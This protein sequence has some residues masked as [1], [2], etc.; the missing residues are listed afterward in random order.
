MSNRMDS[1][2]V[3]P[4]NRADGHRVAGECSRSDPDV[5]PRILD[6]KSRRFKE[7]REA[8]LDAAARLFNSRGIRSTTLSDVAHSVGLATSSVTYYY[9]K[10]DNLVLACILRSL[11]N[12]DGL[13]LL[14]E[15][16]ATSGQRI[17]LF[18][19]SFT[20]LLADVANCD[21]PDFVSFADVSTLTDDG[22]DAGQRHTQIYRR[23]RDLF[24]NDPQLPL[25][26]AQK[27]ARAHLLLTLTQWTRYW[28]D[29]HEPSGYARAARRAADIMLHGLCGP[30]AVWSPPAL[31]ALTGPMVPDD[32][33]PDAFLRAATRLINEEGARF[34]TV[35]RISSELQV[36]RGSFYHHNSKIDDLVEACFRRTFD[37]IRR[38]QSE[39][40]IFA[41]GWEQL[42]AAAAALVQYQLSDAGPL[43]RMTARSRLPEAL[44]GE[45]LRTMHQISEHFAG[46]VADGVIDG[47]VRPVDPAVAAQLISGMINASASARR[48]AP[49]ASP[50]NVVDLYARPLFMGLLSPAY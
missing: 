18:V 19:T 43:L 45:T 35:A 21:R 11:D 32:V 7:K 38:A 2:L 15:Q 16:G 12:F 9:Q 30:S 42:S 46:V 14:A 26:R 29:R 3:S 24:A 1:D 40:G 8:I 49:A 5:A 50:V 41:T 48:W 39:S 22:A 27:N 47:S 34:A 20:Q 44:A 31:D 28:I 37:V 36:T 23:V 33:S 25:S 10:K 13:L 6:T 17:T 4:G